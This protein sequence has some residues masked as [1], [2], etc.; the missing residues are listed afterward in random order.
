MDSDFDSLDA[1]G[2]HRGTPRHNSDQAGPRHPAVSAP[3]SSRPRQAWDQLLDGKHRWGG[4]EIGLPKQGFR[5]YRLTVYP[6]G[7]TNDDRR[8]LR[9]ARSWPTWGAVMFVASLVCLG[10]ALGPWMGLVASAALWLAAG[11]WV[12]SRTGDL[13]ARVRTFGV[14]LINRHHDPR[15]AARFA[16]METVV[17]ALTHADLLLEQNKISV[18]HHELIWGLAYD[19]LAPDHPDSDEQPP[20]GQQEK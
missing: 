7:T 13:S 8:R 5:W 17:E 10:A 18:T 16:L 11:A 1:S 12:L 9:L 19:R 14:I 6:P 4:V 3:P 20:L 2:G 15:T